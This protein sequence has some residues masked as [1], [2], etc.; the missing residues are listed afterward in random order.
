MRTRRRGFTLVE[1][2]L[3][4]AVIMVLMSLS[5]PAMQEARE[6]A[7]RSVCENHLKQMGLAMHNYHD[8]HRTFPPGWV[9]QTPAAGEGPYFG[10]GTFLLP[11]LDQAPLFSKLAFDKVSLNRA[12]IVHALWQTGK[13]T[14]GR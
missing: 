7:R 8:T 14:V 9:S 10:W 3:I 6:A 5:L 12:S 13:S 11:F 1:V 4:A 2:V